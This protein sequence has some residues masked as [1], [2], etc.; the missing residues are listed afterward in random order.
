MKAS[1]ITGQ[2]GYYLA[3]CRIRLIA[4]VKDAMHGDVAHM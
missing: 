1:L 3:E 2:D 4:W